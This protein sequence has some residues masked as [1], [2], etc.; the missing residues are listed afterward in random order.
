MMLVSLNDSTRYAQPEQSQQPP[1]QLPMVY[2]Y[3]K[4]IWEY[5][6]VVR[7]VAAELASEEELNAL[8]AVGW[9]LAGVIA[10][11]GQAQFYFK[12]LRK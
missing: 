4:Q 11:P 5:K 10:L 12:R 9:E 6:I 7:D 8:G 2:V 3:E 1:R